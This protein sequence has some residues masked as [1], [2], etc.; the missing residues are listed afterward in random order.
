MTKLLKLV[1]ELFFMGL[2]T[3]W[4][5][6]N[7]MVSGH[8]NYIAVLVVWLLFLQLFYKNRILG[9]TYGIILTVISGFMALAVVSE[10]REFNPGE[11]E[12]LKLLAW[13]LSLFGIGALMGLGMVYNYATTKTEYEDSVLTTV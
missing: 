13:G 8:R 12:G 4:A 1:P 10:Y 6:E 3:Y 5:I 9:L 11:A 2:G 7:Y